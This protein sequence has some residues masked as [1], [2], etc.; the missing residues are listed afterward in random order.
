MYASFL[1]NVSEFKRLNQLSVPMMFGKDIDVEK[2]VQHQAK[3]HKSCY[4]KFNDTKL[5]RAR[6]RELNRT[7]DDGSGVARLQ[8]M[9]G[10][11]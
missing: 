9:V 6:K 8:L 3:W 2:H 7:S 4:L 5:H 11:C 1:K 10:P